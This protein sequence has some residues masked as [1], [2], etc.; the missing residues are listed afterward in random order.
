MALILDLAHGFATQTSG[1]RRGFLAIEGVQE[2][3]R[4]AAF[5][6]AAAG[7]DVVKL[8][9][10]DPRSVLMLWEAQRFQAI[11]G[12]AAAPPSFNRHDGPHKRCCKCYDT[13]DH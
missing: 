9:L 1:S 13:T 10:S 11:P 5:V 8:T 3:K 6:S 7:G 12:A 4:H 2:R